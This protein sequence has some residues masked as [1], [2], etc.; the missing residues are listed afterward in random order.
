M[1]GKSITL[2]AT[3]FVSA[4][5]FTA[6][7]GGETTVGEQTQLRDLEFVPGMAKGPCKKACEMDDAC[8]LQDFDSCIAEC[9]VV[10]PDCMWAAAAVLNCKRHLTC[11]ELEE[12][13]L[14]CGDTYVDFGECVF[15]A[16][17]E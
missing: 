14:Y 2:T 8:G 7:E 17:P 4:F 12:S 6:C 11:E 10:P 9:D 15:G 13:E 1:F 16:A 3:L 5:L